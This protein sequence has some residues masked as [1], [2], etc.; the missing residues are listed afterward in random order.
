[1]ENFTEIYKRNRDFPLSI[2]NVGK[3]FKNA[4][5][6]SKYLKEEIIILSALDDKYLRKEIIILGELDDD[7]LKEKIIILN[8]LDG[9]ITMELET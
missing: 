1:M 7:Y 4:I 5:F 6:I 2:N 8:E 9:E 3:N